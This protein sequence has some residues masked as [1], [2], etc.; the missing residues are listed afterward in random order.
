MVIQSFYKKNKYGS[1]K[2][3]YDGY[4]YHSKAEAN[5]AAE[6]DMRVKAKDIKSW[7]RQKKIEFYAYGK[8]I[9]NYYVDFVIFHNDGVQEYTEIKGFH[10]ETWRLKRKL[11]EAW[12]KSEE[13]QNKYTI[14][15]V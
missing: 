8:H 5:Y 2:Q 12:I 11:M 6:L 9:C 4:S 14:I 13:P 1:V 3:T 7:T 10:T 15:N